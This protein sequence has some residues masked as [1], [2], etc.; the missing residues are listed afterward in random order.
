MVEVDWEDLEVISEGVQTLQTHAE[1][2]PETLMAQRFLDRKQAAE[3]LGVSFHWLTKNA[4]APTA[5]HCFRLGRK[6]Y[7]SKEDLDG[8]LAGRYQPE[9]ES[10]DSD[11]GRS[12]PEPTQAQL[13]HAFLQSRKEKRRHEEH[14][15]RPATAQI[16]G[17]FLATLSSESKQLL[18]QLL[19]AEKQ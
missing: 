8:W 7:Y 5:P 2:D 3:Y 10:S 12:F 19:N 17:Q 6:S 9:S 13:E 14:D 15:S 16:W 18:K 1:R 4:K 11:E